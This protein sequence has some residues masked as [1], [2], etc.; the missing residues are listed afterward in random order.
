MRPGTSGREDGAEEQA[1]SY[2]TVNQPT[3]TPT[4]IDLGIPDLDRAM[5][6]Y[7][8]VFGW[9]FDV[10]PE[11]TGRYTMCLLGVCW[12]RSRRRPPGCRWAS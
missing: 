1:M 8:A 12:R 2:V 9:K 5:E 3:G 6:F 10:G 4:W 11:Q 7:G